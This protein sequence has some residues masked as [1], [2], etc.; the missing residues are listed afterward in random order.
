MT[1]ADKLE[2]II[3]D[4]L[5]DADVVKVV[6]KKDTNREGE[7]L[8]RITVVYR[9]ERQLDARLM[10]DT[11]WRLWEVLVTGSDSASPVVTFVSSSDYEGAVAA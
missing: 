3:R 6:S 10:S 9:G 2:A 8:I 7:P 4:V 11:L 5:R 1:E